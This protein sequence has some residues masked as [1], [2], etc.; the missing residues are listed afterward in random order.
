MAARRKSARNSVLDSSL[1][2]SNVINL[3]PDRPKIN[4]LAPPDVKVQLG[5]RRGRK[6]KDQSQGNDILSMLNGHNKKKAAAPESPG[7][8]PARKSAR[9]VKKEIPT[10][11]NSP[12]IIESKKVLGVVLNGGVK[13]FHEP[14]LGESKPLYTG[15]PI[16][17]FPTAKIKKESLWPTGKKRG[18]KPNGGAAN[19]RNSSVPPEESDSVNDEIEQKYK[20]KLL[21]KNKDHDL[22]SIRKTSRASPIPP[23]PRTGTKLILRTPTSG[24]ANSTPKSR[25]TPASLSRRIKVIS[26]KKP[27]NTLVPNTTEKESDNSDSSDDPTKDNDD[28]CSA[29]GGSGVFICCDTCPKSFHFTCCDPP[30]DECPEDSWNCTECTIKLHPELKKNWGHI[31]LFA[32]LL[33]EHEGRNARE[34]QL[35]KKLRESTFMDVTT[36]LDGAYSDNQLKPELSYTK[37]NGSQIKGHNYNEDLEIDTLY[38]SDSKPYLCHKCGLSGLEKRTL[39]HCDYCPLVWHLDCLQDPLCSSKTMGSKWRCPNHLED[40]LPS[41]LF[42]KRNFKDCSVLDVSLQSHFLEIAS[43]SNILIKHQHQSYFKDSVDVSLQDYAQFQDSDFVRP[44]DLN[45]PP[46]QTKEEGE[47]KLPDYFVNYASSDNKIVSRASKNL[48]KVLCLNDRAND[49]NTPNAFIY[50]IP[51]ELITLSFVTKCQEIQKKRRGRKPKRPRPLPQKTKLL[52]LNEINSYEQR[53]DLE[54]Q[55]NQ[56]VIDSLSELKSTPKIEP[57]LSSPEPLNFQKLVQYASS[58]LPTDEEP[59][60]DP[61]EI[62]DLLHIKKLMQMKGRESLLEFLKS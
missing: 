57:K 52:I 23:S 26:P 41:T 15:L 44:D 11:K 34:F 59:S 56:E 12:V 43:M 50:R 42:T 45:D 1:K 24:N 6:R 35:P 29:C 30:L 62:D 33:N 14:E 31:G 49:T 5:A 3:S 38:D 20:L 32:Q 37:L 21:P 19:S 53:I 8:Q 40:L 51:E 17:A 13:E 27:A 48:S 10:L 4:G 16:E 54:T 58:Q 60:L 28:H 18:P 7:P 46:P 55:Q 25:P 36:E 47:F 61:K 9:L 39:V 22:S 2:L